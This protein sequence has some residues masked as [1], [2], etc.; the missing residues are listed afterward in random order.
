[1]TPPSFPGAH[2]I[3]GDIAYQFVS[4]QS[5]LIR[6][7]QHLRSEVENPCERQSPSLQKHLILSKSDSCASCSA[8]PDSNDHM[9]AISTV[10]PAVRSVSPLSPS[11][12]TRCHHM[13]N[14]PINGSYAGGQYI[15]DCVHFPQFLDHRVNSS[16][17][18]AYSCTKNT[19][20]QVRFSS[21]VP[22]FLCH[23]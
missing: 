18:E 13:F 6:E 16:K 11:S 1:V 2:Q 3:Q 9:N 5:R 14:R 17:P 10:D 21:V 8:F 19:M 12:S 22:F 20:V 15:E 4:Y 23:M 7:E